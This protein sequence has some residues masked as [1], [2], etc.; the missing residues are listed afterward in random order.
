MTDFCYWANALTLWHLWFAPRSLF[1]RRAVFALASGP[2]AL[3]IPAFRNALVFH[4]LDKCTSLFIHVGPAL[5]AWSLR[6]H[7]GALPGTP[8]TLATVAA[9]RGMQTCAYAAAA[10]GW[11]GL[12]RAC[13]G[14]VRG[15][16]PLPAG[17]DAARVGDLLAAASLPYATWALA[18]YVIMFN[19]LSIQRIER[20]GFQTMWKYMV[21]D[22]PHSFLSRLIDAAPSPAYGPVIYMLAH[23]AATTASLCLAGV[24]WRCQAAHSLFIVALIAASAYNGATY[25]LDYLLRVAVRES[26]KGGA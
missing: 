7:P 24:W 15:R 11:G 4:S 6:W 1:L 20:K 19:P 2:L 5:V 18:Y 16:P 25:Y 22:R 13:G 14:G 26:G 23:L 8:P 17:W 21:I 12:A 10:A 3:S 9:E